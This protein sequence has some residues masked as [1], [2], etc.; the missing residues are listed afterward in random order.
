L[1]ILFIVFYETGRYLNNP[2]IVH[3]YLVFLLLY[4]AIPRKMDMIFRCSDKL[5]LI[6]FGVSIVFIFS[7]VYPTVVISSYKLFLRYIS[8]Y[9]LAAAFFIG[10]N[11]I[12][13]LSRIRSTG[14]VELLQ[15]DDIFRNNGK[16]E[17]QKEGGS[18]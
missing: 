17:N 1:A 13:M 5:Y 10:F 8:K 12:F 16:D 4:F 2:F 18:K 14:V 3:F 6:T 15:S 7:G 11:S 9:S